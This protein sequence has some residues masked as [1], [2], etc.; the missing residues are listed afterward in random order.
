LLDE[1]IK[2]VTTNTYLINLTTLFN[3]AISNAIIDTNPAQGIRVLVKEEDRTKREPFSLEQLNSFF[4]S[5]IYEQGFRPEGGKGD[6]A[7]WIPLVGLYSGA[8]LNEICQLTKNDITHES[9]H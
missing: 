2:T 9:Y 1:D 8:R 4:S 7:F 3:Y 6:A 5:P